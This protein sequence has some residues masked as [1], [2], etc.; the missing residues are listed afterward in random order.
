MS[1]TE[2]QFLLLSTDYEVLKSVAA[3]VRA[4]GGHLHCSATAAA[5]TDIT[6]RRRL[7]AVLVDLA[8]PA[9]LNLITDLRSG[10]SNRNIVIF[11]CTPGGKEDS[12]ALTAGANF[13]LNRPLTEEKVRTGLMAARSMM[14]Q[15]RRRYFR[16]PVSIPAWLSQGEVEERVVATDMS[17]GGMAIRAAQ[18]L[19]PPVQVAFR[20]ELPKGPAIDGRGEVAW[21]NAAGEMGVRFR[22]FRGDGESLLR[23]WLERREGASPSFS[24]QSHPAPDGRRTDT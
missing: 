10:K 19:A 1:T 8:L 2:L 5:A 15:E 6:Q 13:L 11:A 22:F 21:A 9:S 7:D 14:I 23:T 16:H 12:I 17:E 3:A 24:A 18:M 20:F 4:L